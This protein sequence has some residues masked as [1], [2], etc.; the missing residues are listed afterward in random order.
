MVEL[1]DPLVTL[2]RLQERMPLVVA[3]AAIGVGSF[4]TLDSEARNAAEDN[5]HLWIYLCDWRL[6]DGVK[7]IASSDR[8][9]AE[10]Q[11]V[12][13]GLVSRKILNIVESNPGRIDLIFD[14]ELRLMLKENLNMYSIEDDMLRIYCGDDVL[15]YSGK[16]GFYRL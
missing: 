1:N 5:V 4:F 14:G 9:M 13:R 11:G 15:G 8:D 12:V 16:R 6:K 7:L 10:C 3:K 2:R